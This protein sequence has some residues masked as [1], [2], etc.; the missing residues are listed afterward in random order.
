V[1]IETTSAVPEHKVALVVAGGYCSMALEMVDGALDD[2]SPLILLG[3][4]RRCA[5]SHS[6]T[7]EPVT[8][9][10]SRLGNGCLDPTSPQVGPNR[11]A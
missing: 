11:T 6:P 4:E 10:I 2:V 7:L 9:L 5:P 8:T 1:R 3:V